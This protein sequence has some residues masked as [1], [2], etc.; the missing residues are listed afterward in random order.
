M[1]VRKG[2]A[3]QFPVFTLYLAFSAVQN[4]LLFVLDHSASV[5]PKQYWT[6]HWIG[7]GI[8]TLL[9]FALIYEIFH[10]VFKPYP[11][12]LR[13]SKVVMRW[14]AALLFLIAVVGGAYFPTDNATLIQSAIPVADCGVNFMQAG[15]L[16][17]LFFFSSYFH[18]SWR[19]YV[20]GIA[21]GLGVFS[22]VKLGIIALQLRLGWAPGSSTFNLVI[23]A[24]YHGCLLIWLAYLLARERTRTPSTK[25]PAH[26]LEDWNQELQRLLTP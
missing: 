26:N 1:M 18:L 22:L 12:L 6:V 11:S 17:F 14:A 19:S 20:F 4:M 21:M 8:S 23:M 13:F 3:R 15:L 16:L 25:L 5:S 2:L 10:H 7:M 24:T 9:R